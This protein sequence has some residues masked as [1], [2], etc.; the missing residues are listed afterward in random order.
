MGPT[1][2]LA[3]NPDM[4]P[5]WESNQQPFGSQPSLNPLSYSSQGASDVLMWASLPLL[6][7]L[8]RIRP[9][10]VWSQLSKCGHSPCSKPF[11]LVSKHPSCIS[12][13][14]MNL[15]FPSHPLALTVFFFL[16]SARVRMKKAMDSVFV[17]YIQRTNPP[18]GEMVCVVSA[19]LNVPFDL[20][21]RC[22]PPW[23]CRTPTIYRRT[24]IYG[25]SQREKM[26]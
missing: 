8:A 13:A 25:I 11:L 6:V 1:R 24:G 9:I 5:D 23:L 2:D 20:T 10:I 15:Q 21:G 12:M 26:I 19:L 4:C 17:S 7:L 18:S 16:L 22:W 14:N 3:F